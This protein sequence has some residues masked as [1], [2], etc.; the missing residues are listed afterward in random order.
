MFGKL[1]KRAI[2]GRKANRVAVD[3]YLN[4][5]IGNEPH[6]ARARDISTEGIYI[7]K[8]L[9]PQQSSPG[10]HIGLEF[11]LPGHD[12]TIWAVGEV[13]RDE[14]ALTTRRKI[15]EDGVALKFTRLKDSDRRKIHHFV[16][17]R[18]SQAA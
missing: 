11:Q 10:D 1:R 5:I 3:F 13:V 7:Y 9:E 12:K 4:K 15:P 14:P 18:R 8:I 6:L 16:Q 17:M 2:I